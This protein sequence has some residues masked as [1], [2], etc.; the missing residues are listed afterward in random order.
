MCSINEAKIYLIN[1]FIIDWDDTL[2]PSA[3]VEKNGI[4]LNN[5]E[6]VSQYKLYFSE[7]DRTIGNFF[8]GFCKMGDIYIVTNAGMRWIKTCLNCLP[9]TSNIIIN[10]SIRIISARDAYSQQTN[11]PVEWKILTFQN[12]FDNILKKIQDKIK[13]N[14]YLNI[15]SFGDAIYE[16][17]ALVNL[18]SYIQTKNILKN[19]FTHLLKSIK[20]INKPDFNVIIDQLNLIHKD[21]SNIVNKL[22]FSDFIFE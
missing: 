10:N 16:Y 2:F 18:D 14:S 22:S 6:S 3:W 17:I 13:P 20:F 19:K 1:A 21:R 12:L 15:I 9:I 7:L 4:N 5:P 11:S 8:A